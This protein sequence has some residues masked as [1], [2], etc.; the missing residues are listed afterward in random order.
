MPWP[1]DYNSSQSPQRVIQVNPATGVDITPPMVNPDGSTEVAGVNGTSIATA[2]NPLP[3]RDYGSASIATSQVSV[4]TSA[5]QIVPARSGRLAVTITM[6]G[7]GDVFVGA[8]G[9]TVANGSLLLGVKGS[10]VTI[11]TQAAVFGIG[12]VAQT[13]TVLE[14][15]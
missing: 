14:T 7:G 10:S 11:P 6:A 8:T 13:V 5:T 12:A 4:G 9:V 2:A 15:F 1:Q 3:T